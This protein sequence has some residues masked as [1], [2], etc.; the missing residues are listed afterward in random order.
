MKKNKFYVY[1]HINRINGKIYI[2]KTNCPSRRW[3][4]ANYTG[5]TFFYHAIQKYGWNNFDHVI[6]AQCSTEEDAFKFEEQYISYYNTT[7]SKIGY[8]ITSGGLGAYKPGHIFAHKGKHGILPPPW[9]KGI[10]MSEETRRKVSEAKKGKKYGP[11]S[12]EHILHKALAH[13]IKILQ[14]SLNGE[15]I[16][17][18]NSGADIER[19]IGISKKFISRAAKFHITCHNYLWFK[20]SEFTDE[21]LIDSVLK[22]NECI[23]HYSKEKIEDLNK[24]YTVT[25]GIFTT[26]PND[27]IY[28]LN[29][30]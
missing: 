26:R 21:L 10:P 29:K 24:V 27:I 8:N 30:I 11:Q 16:K 2:G 20:K 28:F 17:E 5:C 15:F 22:I 12:K 18:W 19:E 6:L 7:N 9:N 4:A 25:P 3:M 14:Y 1:A 23:E 13:K